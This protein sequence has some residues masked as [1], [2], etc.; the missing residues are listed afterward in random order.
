MAY[1]IYLIIPGIPGE[2]QTQ[3]FG[4]DATDTPIEVYS[5][6]WGLSNLATLHGAGKASFSDVSIQ[7]RFDK[8]SPKLMQAL[9]AGQHLTNITFHFVKA[10]ANSEVFLTYEFDNVFVT[11]VSDS[12]STGGDSSPSESVS[13]AMG[14]AK[15]T[16]YPQSPDGSLSRNPVIFSW[17]LSTIQA[18]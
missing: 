6:S 18:P 8:S 16:Y 15:V 5:F 2:S 10:G 9:V 1:D 3:L 4:T 13:F 7:K 12:A 14:S 11:S 17:D